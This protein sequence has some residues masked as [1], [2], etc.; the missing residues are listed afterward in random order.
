MLT[1]TAI[2][3]FY[4]EENCLKES[5]ERLTVENIFNKILLIDNN[6]T[7]N[8]LIIAKKLEKEYSIVQVEQ[9]SKAKGK[10]IAI[11]YSK[12][13]IDTS[14]V[15]IHDADLE[16]F[17]KDIVEMYDLAKNNP[18]SF[19]LGSR[20]IGNKIRKN[21][22][23]RA[24]W[25]N[26]FLSFL[27]SLVFNIKVSDIA[28]CYKLIPSDFIKNTKLK[29]NGFTIDLELI[30]KFVKTGNKVLEVPIMYEGR[31]YEEGKK[32]K[33]I[34]FFR[35]IYNIIRYRF[36]DWWLNYKNIGK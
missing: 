15:V 13:F 29:E 12:N 8:S 6:S 24:R 22:Y 11:Q 25:A 30:T 21:I 2:V 9:T 4:N 3:P 7:D 34:D 14:H 31:S 10:G 35:Y 19:I 20:L 5:V 36:V 26:Q 27:F 23:P 16:Y 33:T 1:L 18:S 17:P 32:I 28:S